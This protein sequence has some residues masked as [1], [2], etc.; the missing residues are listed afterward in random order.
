MPAAI[1]S[2]TALP[3]DSTSSKLAMITCA[4]CGLGIRR[5][6]TSVTTASMPSEPITVASRSRPGASGAS[7]PNSTTSPS[8]IT[9]RTRSTLCTVRPYL[10]QCTPPEFS[11]TLPPMVQAICDD[12]SG[13]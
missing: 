6:V 3:P 11:L 13:A 8:I 1:T 5:T 4:N 7:L 10:R 2:A 12:G 9:A